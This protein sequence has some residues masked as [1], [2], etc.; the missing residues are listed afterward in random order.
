MEIVPGVYETLISKAIEDRLRSF[1]KNQY[2]V[3]KEDIDS[4]DSYKIL[5]DY[6][7]EVVANIL[8]SHF[9][10]KDRKDTISNQVNVVNR[11]LKFIEEEWD[12][13]HVD[14]RISNL[15]TGGN[16]IS[17]DDEVR[18]DIQTADNI[19]LIVSFIKFEGLRLL[20]DDLLKFV[21]RNGTKLR[22]LTTTYM[23]A[24]DPKA[25]RKLYE[26]R[27]YGQVDIRASYNT[28][29]E[30][31]HAK[32]YIF[33]RNNGFDTAY[34]GSSNISRSALTKGL[35]WNIRV[36]SVENRH[37]ISKTQATFDNYWNSYD[38][39]PI[40][41]E[42]ALK[43]FEDAIRKERNYNDSNNNEVEYITRFERKTHQIKVLAKLQYE[44]EMIHSRK[45]LIIAATGTGKTAI[46][47]FDFKDYNQQCIKEKGRKARL[48]F[49]VHREKILKQA[50][51]TFRSVMV[52]ANFGEIWTGRTQ[53]NY[54]SNLDHL[55]ITIQTLNNNWDTIE[56]MGCDYYDYVVI[57]EVHHSQA[58]SYRSI[59]EKLKPEIFIG[60]TAT[61]ERMDGKEIKPDFNN[62]F[63]AEIRLRE[64]L[65]QQLL[66]PFD[67]FCVTD[68][69]V[70]LSKIE[71]KYSGI[72]TLNRKIKKGD[73]L[74]KVK[75]MYQG[76]T[77]DTY[78]VYLDK[79]IKYYNYYLLLIPLV[80]IILIIRI[81]IKLK[82]SKRKIKRPFKRKR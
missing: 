2:L 52:D 77:L 36:T 67:Y 40:D 56:Q 51:F 62:R 72:D 45:N 66:A 31:L 14:Y 25:I 6:L 26:L 22:I 43:R 16:D 44:R 24:T 35:E 41:D 38:F 19:D 50:R 33:H 78:K 68:D 28:K 79:D 74:G 64:A 9:C 15:F 37:I 23:G 73:Y 47:A 60:L 3:K 18:R 54:S 46:S 8:K 30:R 55:F 75:I 49:I 10:E 71:Y 82:K 32:S 4:A 20:Y 61:P 29:Q 11:I 63:A 76:D 12:T 39:E 42:D 27:Q 53:P 70:D 17:M 57:D 80:I 13:Q 21:E 48:L 58:G 34:I 1:P 69:S 59:F 81:K 7:A 5:A 65:D